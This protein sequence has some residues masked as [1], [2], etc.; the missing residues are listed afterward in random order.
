MSQTPYAET[1][2]LLAVLEG[3]SDDARKMVAAMYPGEARNLRMACDKLADLYWD[4]K[5]NEGFKVP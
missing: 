3:R 1:E 5:D 2:A 4:I